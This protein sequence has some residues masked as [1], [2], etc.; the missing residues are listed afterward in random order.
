MLKSKSFFPTLRNV[1]KE[2]TSNSHKLMIKAGLIRQLGSGLYSWISTH[3]SIMV[4]QV[5]GRSCATSFGTK[6]KL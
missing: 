3:T 6:R 5:H 2:I 1:N 4:R